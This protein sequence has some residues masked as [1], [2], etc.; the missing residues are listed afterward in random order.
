MFCISLRSNG[1]SDFVPYVR[2]IAGLPAV[3]GEQRLS[4][5]DTDRG[6]CSSSVGFAST[7]TDHGEERHFPFMPVTRV[8]YDEEPRARSSKPEETWPGRAPSDGGSGV[9]ERW[10]SLSTDAEGLREVVHALKLR[11]SRYPTA[12]PL[13]LADDG[14]EV[15]GDGSGGDSEE[16]EGRAASD[17]SHRKVP[18]CTTE[19]FLDSE[20]HLLGE[21]HDYL[22]AF[23]PPAVD[24]LAV[25]H[26]GVTQNN[27]SRSDGRTPNMKSS[28]ETGTGEHG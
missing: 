1:P 28:A 10:Q 7:D 27:E 20:K 13:G 17:D 12:D 8:D 4:P 11:L 21:L 6:S 5:N 26:G 14:G 18:S 3:A 24:V 19:V 25:P 22:A 15:I 2:I 16:S 23:L 9:H